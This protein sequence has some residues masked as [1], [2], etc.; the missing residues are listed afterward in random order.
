MK[1]KIKELIEQE[2]SKNKTS[3]KFNSGIFVLNE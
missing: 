3:I 1:K 2:F